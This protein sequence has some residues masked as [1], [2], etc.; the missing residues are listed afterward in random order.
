MNNENC[1]KL[2][3]EYREKNIEKSQIFAEER[4][5]GNTAELRWSSGPPLIY[6]VVKPAS[7]YL[8]ASLIICNSKSVNKATLRRF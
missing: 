5:S 1:L 6:S 3:L 4:R 8:N 7:V 2:I